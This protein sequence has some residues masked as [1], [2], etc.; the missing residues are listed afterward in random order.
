MEINLEIKKGI[1]KEI[2]IQQF[3]NLK[4]MD[5]T[6]W[7]LVF[8]YGKKRTDVGRIPFTFQNIEHAEQMW[9]DLQQFINTPY[10][11]L[12]F[13]EQFKEAVFKYLPLSKI[14]AKKK[15]KSKVGFINI[16]F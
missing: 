14:K 1:I 3:I 16:P 7:G 12:I 15:Q 8:R 4:N 2:Y 10:E 9:D 6:S 5:I 11:S 13:N